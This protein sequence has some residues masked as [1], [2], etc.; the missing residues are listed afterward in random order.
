MSGRALL[1]G[2]T[3]Y[4][5]RLV[6]K[7]LASMGVDVILA[8][9]DAYAVRSVAE[10]LR[11]S[12]TAFDLADA[13]DIERALSHVSVVLHAA[14]PFEQTAKPMLDACLETKR[15]YLDLNGEWP[16]FLDAMARDREA[17]DAG[18]M[19]M[20]GVGLTITA[21]DCL[22]ALAYKA[23]PNAVA[24][25]LGVSRPEVVTR[26]TVVSAATLTSK[27][28]VVRRDHRLVTVPAGS[29]CHAFDFGR[30][31]QEATALSWADVVTGGFTT[32]V[33]DITVYSQ[34]GWTQRASYRASAMVMD[35]TGAAPW[36]KLG[37]TLAKAWPETPRA[38]ALE[39]ARF[40]MVAE[41]IDPWRRVRRVR[42]GTLDGYA[43]SELTAAEAV[44]QVLLGRHKPGFQTPA[45]MFG[46]A[47]ILTLGCAELYP[48]H[49]D[50]GAST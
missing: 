2:A 3:G 30:G 10:P 32:G 46:A 15:H 45:R 20:P 34:L 26:G 50:L 5:G 19:V 4:T 40:V 49:D 8:G 17:R 25:R 43:V 48:W 24:L 12:W 16:G 1:Y 18:I 27:D 47:F 44:R 23:Q 35:V 38:S 31:L 41:A 29:L 39:K 21:T 6:A 36:R 37:A 42:M 33:G 11:L 13:A 7:R 9:R 14:G 22:L 28:V